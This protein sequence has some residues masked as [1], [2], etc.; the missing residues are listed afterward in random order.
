MIQN[1]IRLYQALDQALAQPDEAASSTLCTGQAQL[2][3]MYLLSGNLHLLHK[4]AL[5]L[6]ISGYQEESWDM[7]GKGDPSVFS[8]SDNFWTDPLSII[9]LFQT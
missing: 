3:A 9:G 6:W 8:G 1:Y 4:H 5:D 2:V 7:T